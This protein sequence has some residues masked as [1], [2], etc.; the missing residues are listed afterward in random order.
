MTRT[1]PTDVDEDVWQVPADW[2]V[3]PGRACGPV[4]PLDP[5]LA[6]RWAA[7]CSESAAWLAAQVD[8]RH[9][10][11]RQACD[12]AGDTAH[13][14]SGLTALESLASA[15][16]LGAAVLAQVLAKSH[17]WSNGD[18]AVA[19][20]WVHTYG[21]V[22]AAEAAVLLADSS[23]TRHPETDVYRPAPRRP[24]DI[25]DSMY[26]PILYRIRLHLSMLPEDTYRAVVARLEELRGPDAHPVA[27]IATSILAPTEQQWVDADIRDATR[28]ARPINNAYRLLLM[29]ITTREQLD[30]L[31]EK[32]GRPMWGRA[33]G[34]GVA[35]LGADAA[36]LLD[37]LIRDAR[38]GWE[39]RLADM[40][41]HLPSDEAFSF[42]LSHV[43]PP[44][45]SAQILTAMALYPRR[46]MRVLAGQEQPATAVRELR[47]RYARTR[48]ELA[49][50]LGIPVPPRTW[51][52]LD[53]LPEPLRMPLHEQRVTRVARA[54]PAVGSTF[55]HRPVSLD[56]LPGEQAR[57][58]AHH[59]Q[60]RSVSLVGSADAAGFLLTL[61]TKAGD[62]DPTILMP[63]TGTQVTTLM[64]GWLNG[65]KHHLTALRWFDRHIVTAAPDLIAA[66]LDV[67]GKSRTAA[68]KAVR[69][70]ADR[71]R[72]T[73]LAT[74]MVLAPDA[75][76][77]VTTVADSW[78]PPKDIP[79]P[80]DWL[81]LAG[82]PPIVLR[83]SG[84]AVP[85]AAV[86]TL[87]TML[88]VIE[89]HG[90][91]PSIAQLAALAEPDSLRDFAWGLFEAW[92]FSGMA[93]GGIW[94][95][96]ALA[97]FGDDE[98]AW[99]LEP[100]I[101]S[102][103][104]SAGSPAE[105]ALRVLVAIDSD[106]SLT[107]LRRISQQAKAKAFKKHASVAVRQIADARGF[108]D[109]QFADRL[110][111]DF[112]LGETGSLVIDYGTRA[113][114]VR[115]DQRLSPLVFDAVPDSHGGWGA[116][117]SRKVLPRPTAKDDQDKAVSAYQAH[118]AFKE[119]L[120]S[121]AA[122]Q[123][124]RLELAMLSGRRWSGAEQQ[125]LFI[126]HPV[127]QHLARS[128]VWVVFDESGAVTGSFR[129]AEDGSRADIDD[130]AVKLAD[131]ALVGIAHPVH[132]GESVAE[133]A[134]L[135]A[136]YEILAPFPQ[137]DR[138]WWTADSPGFDDVLDRLT[139]RS[140]RT[141]TVLALKRLGWQWE[142]DGGNVVTRLWRTLAGRVHAELTVEPGLWL[143][144]FHE[145][146]KQTITRATVHGATLRELDPIVASELI[147]E[148][149]ILS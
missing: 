32:T 46:A 92:M 30:E 19:S 34:E 90:K 57:W 127:L 29:S 16:P 108:T 23:W 115:I 146:E 130:E 76:G 126:E 121:T 48:P 2:P 93:D 110:V 24:D 22:F 20:G 107:V 42:L 91:H 102:W 4:A 45:I 112:G 43:D 118:T 125:R 100:I 75:F 66:I 58:A 136:D 41:A 98:T 7:Y 51:A 142:G 74:A 114:L 137:L 49:A 80:P 128:L 69:T 104:Y 8:E 63:F 106:A 145:D 3:A 78:T 1:M 97:L 21:P 47:D 87:V 149:G 11:I 141:G 9:S 71:H 148:L 131:D 70:L 26:T 54:R 105:A 39:R 81:L 134:G 72:D 37:Q 61:G 28:P 65:K 15:T 62:I 14:A 117:G 5:E 13:G 119:I 68:D 6:A 18:A 82:L 50:E 144:R 36:T 147:R 44:R 122:T 35:R 31:V 55:E 73:L 25:S 85:D 101:R 67:P 77:T 27:R 111:P 139:D 52:N 96:R 124:K 53:A 60:R 88:A 84:L 17:R 129:I 83:D 116:A 64:I 138:L 132:L 38:H 56:W 89:S 33:L 135:F 95:M 40:L 120:K 59:D 143:G 140:V 94:V 109:E 103:Y 99:R 86:H 79:A 123:T 12:A 10:E 133:W 113:F